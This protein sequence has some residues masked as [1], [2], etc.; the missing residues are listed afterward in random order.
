MVR[1]LRL[2]IP[3]RTA[4][5]MSLKLTRLNAEHCVNIILDPHEVQYEDAIIEKYAL[6]VVPGTR[7]IIQDDF[8]QFTVTGGNVNG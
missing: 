8:V 7:R 1:L 2:D 4:R 3:P 5:Y 6:V